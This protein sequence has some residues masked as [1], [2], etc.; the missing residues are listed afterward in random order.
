MGHRNTIFATVLSLVIALSLFIPAHA[1]TPDPLAGW[2]EDRI[3]AFGDVHGG[4]AELR[5]LLQAMHMIDTADNWIGGQTRLVSLGDLL[6]RGPDSRSVMDLLMRLEVQAAAAGGRLYMVLGNHEIMNL[7]GDLRYVSSEE[8]AAFAADEDPQV[9]AA[10]LSDFRAAGTDSATPESELR[11]FNGRFPPGYFGHRAAFSEEGHY[12]RW[13]LSKPQILELAQMAF[14]HG[15]LSEHFSSTSI[16]Q[17]NRDADEELHALLTIG[18][19]LRSNDQLEPWADFLTAPILGP[20]PIVP[21]ELADLRSALQFQPDG[22]SWYRGTASCHPLLEQSRFEAVLRSRALKKVIMGHT[23]TIPRIP[24]GRFGDRA[25]LADTGMYRAYYRGRPSALAFNGDE[26]QAFTLTD[27]GIKPIPLGRTPIDVRVGDEAALISAIKPNLAAPIFEDGET[28]EITAA[29]RRMMLTWRRERTNQQDA[30]IAAYLLDKQLGLGLVAPILSHTVND[31]TGTLEILPGSAIS[32]TE[33]VAQN[34]YRPN[35]CSE[36]S[37][38]DLMLILDALIGQPA[39]DSSNVWYDRA[40]WLMYL[41][42]HGRAFPGSRSLPAYVV[43]RLDSQQTGIPPDL[44]EQLAKL[45]IATLEESLGEYLS[46]R[47]LQ[48]I[49]AR[50]DR[51]LEQTHT[52]R[53][54]RE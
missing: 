14:V 45:T 49:V 52:N 29:G 39:R 50:R 46:N 32:E 11:A 33:R 19:R 31:R 21:A 38:Y 54:E 4:A 27:D 12:G 13:L 17:F 15:G 30:R 6:D 8:Y 34:R 37:D 18:N 42:D 44:T 25:L 48:A 23:P 9:R 47:Q 5:S 41:V 3:V 36:G 43:N 10:A 22:P 28:R 24:Q 51:L 26:V 1:D 16:E 40:T 20:D 2:P 53:P 7:V 35:Y